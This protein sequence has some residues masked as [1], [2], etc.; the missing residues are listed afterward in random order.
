MDRKV[1][2]ARLLGTLLTG[3][4]VVTAAACGDDDDDDDSGFGGGDNDSV[5]VPA[6]GGAATAQAG[7]SPPLSSIL[8]RKIIFTAGITLSVKDVAGSFSEVSRLATSVGGFVERSSFAN[9]EDVKDRTASLALRVP[10]ARYEETLASLRGLT[11][12]S[13]KTESSNSS[14]VTE[15]YTDLQSRIRNLERTEQQYLTLLGRATTIQEILTVQDRLDGVRLQ[16][17]QIQGRLNVLDDLADLATIDVTLV[18]LLP[19]RVSGDDGPKGVTEAFAD[20]WDWFMEASRYVAAGLAIVAVAA[21]FLA[22]PAGVVV[23]IAIV[24]RRLRPRALPS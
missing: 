8:D 4:L 15:E 19:A 24:V 2:F 16:I 22:L 14:E 6:A 5:G 9:A 20:A 7:D 10:A 23:G 12:G 3:A 13:V 11:G 1:G 21:I 17:E 18:P